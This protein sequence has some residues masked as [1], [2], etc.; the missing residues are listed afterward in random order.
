[1]NYIIWVIIYLVFAVLFAQE[2]K[3]VNKNSKN[4]SALTVLLE[5]MNGYLCT[6]II[7]TI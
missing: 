2:F 5:L 4:I 6:S 7:T 3:K 1:M